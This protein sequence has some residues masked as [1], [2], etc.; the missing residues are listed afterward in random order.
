M[1]VI[2][3]VCLCSRVCLN[4]CVHTG[5]RVQM[6]T[7]VQGGVCVLQV[8]GRNAAVWGFVLWG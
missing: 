7:G 6:N 8:G 5:I 3:H 4:L 2:R 1:F